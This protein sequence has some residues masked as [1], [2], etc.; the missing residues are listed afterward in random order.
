LKILALI[1]ARG[2]SK[3]IP[4][5]NIKLLGGKPLIAHAAN[6][7]S[8]SPSISRLIISTDSEE[9][10][11]VAS[12]HGI[13]VPFIR[14]QELALDTTPSIDVMIH[15]LNHFKNIGEAFDAICLLQATSPFKP[16]NFV[17]ECI[18]TFIDSGADSFISVLRVPHEYNPHWT[19]EKNELGELRIA[20]GEKELIPRRQELPPAFYRDGCVYITKTDYLLQEKKIVGGKITCKESNPDYYCNL[21]TLADWAKAE[22]MIQ[23]NPQLLP[24]LCVE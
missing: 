1:P 11:Q 3:G 2:G 14:P 6:S 8:Q 18:Q 4:G 9:I 15:A 17:N 21:D 5:K 24:E 19:F 16:K 7:A 13:E 12:I 20:T 22:Q 10:A 23:Q